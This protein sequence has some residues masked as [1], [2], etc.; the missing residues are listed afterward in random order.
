MSSRSPA[1]RHSDE[2]RQWVAALWV[3]GRTASE[4][5]T[6]SS[7]QLTR[8][9]ICGLV[10]R[11]GLHRE[12][13]RGAAQRPQ[14]SRVCKTVKPPA[15]PRAVQ[16][17]RAKAAADLPPLPV[18]QHDARRPCKWPSGDVA[19]GLICG[20]ARDPSDWRSLYCRDHRAIAVRPQKG[21]AVRLRDRPAPDVLRAAVARPFRFKEAAPR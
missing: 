8:S 18:E 6:L 17:V 10:N 13:G 7:G 2:L 19:E 1:N 16:S 9:A 15:P 20:R 21:G 11:M 4:I 12:A 14:A 3:A 5:E